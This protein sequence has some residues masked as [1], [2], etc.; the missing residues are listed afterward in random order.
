[1]LILHRPLRPGCYSTGELGAWMGQEHQ[2]W[3]WT[4]LEFQTQA[5]TSCDFRR[6]TFCAWAS[7]PSSVRG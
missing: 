4:T 6:V 5:L 1:M 7:F 3:G 2:P